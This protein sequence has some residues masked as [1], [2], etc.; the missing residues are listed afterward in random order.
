LLA[1]IDGCTLSHLGA[2]GRRKRPIGLNVCRGAA[3]HPT[4]LVVDG[5]LSAIRGVV[6][7]LLIAGLLAAN[8]RR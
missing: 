6:V 8:G 3:N 4:V 1:L 7:V 2:L 5:G